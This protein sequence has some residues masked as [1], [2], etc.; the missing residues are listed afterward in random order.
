MRLDITILPGD[1][2]GP[3]VTREAVRVLRTVLDLYGYEVSFEER[4]I[5]GVAIRQFG[6]PLPEATA[7]ACTES[8]AVL[9]GAVGGPEFDSLPAGQRPEAGLLGLRQAL[10]GYAN[11]RPAVAYVA[12]ADCSP[13]RADIIKGAD[14]LIVRE[15]L[16]GIYFGEPRGF[17]D[18]PAPAAYNTM[19]YSEA[20]I[21]RVA[22]VAFRQARMRHR[23]VTSV[24]KANVLETSQLW[25]QTVTRVAREYPEIRLDHMYVDACAMRLITHPG[26]FDVIVTENL[27]GDILSD[28][29]AVISGSLGMLASATIGGKVDL[30][31]PVHGSAPD[32][33][34]RGIA[35]PLGAIASAA[36]LLRHSAG[37]EQ[38]A[39]DIEDAIR[40]VLDKG[41]RTADLQRTRAKRVVSTTEMGALVESAVADVVDRRRAYHAV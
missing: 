3:E 5:G 12:I 4:A 13:L 16:G 1:G 27:F 30:Y 19:R 40:E 35:N 31:E 39:Q 7:R 37:L 21:E 2:V 17:T 6:T 33:A 29:A 26:S 32:I 20:E 11:L 10:G 18:S 15:L 34:G 38:G 24:D 9:L 23:K 36:L 28:E 8:R 25:R 41:H 14:V 22:H